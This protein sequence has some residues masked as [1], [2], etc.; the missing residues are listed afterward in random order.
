MRLYLG[1]RAVHEL[2]RTHTEVNMS[3]LLS[4]RKNMGCY[5]T[6]RAPP[7]CMHAY[8]WRDREA[9]RGKLVTS[10]PNKPSW[11]HQNRCWPEAPPG[12][13]DDL[14]KG[15]LRPKVLALQEY[16]VRT[17]WGNSI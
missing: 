2:G 7:S 5:S 1:V 3:V 4:V 10:P 16:Q 8:V 15:A 13:L 17:S 11:K 14:H 9:D 12:S 6:L